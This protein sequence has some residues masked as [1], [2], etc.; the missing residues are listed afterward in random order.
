MSKKVRYLNLPEINRKFPYI[1]YNA[2]IT[3]AG[4]GAP[5]AKE[6]QNELGGTPVFARTSAGVYTMTLASAFVADK[7][8]AMISK[9][10][11]VGFFSIERTSANVLTIKTS[12]ADGTATDAL[13]TDISISIRVYQN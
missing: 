13:L 6:L 10:A 5:T 3:Q 2:L 9:N 12:I 1:E 4:T 8:L 11:I 7:T